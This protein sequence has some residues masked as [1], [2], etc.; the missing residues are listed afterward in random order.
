MKVSKFALVICAALAGAGGALT[1]TACSSSSNGSSSGGSGSSSGGGSDAAADT[2]MEQG[3]TGMEVDSGSG[4]GSGSSSGGGS[5]DC[6]SIPGLHPNPAGDIFCGY[7]AADGGTLDCLT[8]QQCCLGGSIGG[9]QFAA[10]ECSTWTTDGS[11]CNNPDGGGL[12]ITCNQTSDCTANG[13]D[14]GYASCCLV[15]ASEATVPGCGYPKAKNGSSVICETTASCQSGEIQICS[16]Q[17]DCP[18]GKTCTAG[19]WKLYQ[20]GFCL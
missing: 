19:K 6:G 1:E 20:L 2:S 15:G 14:A 8:G 9:G 10:E 12:G 13:P 3:D 5:P 4:S 18:S 7:G 16:S 17:S 11:G